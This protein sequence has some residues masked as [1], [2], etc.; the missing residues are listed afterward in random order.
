[1]N[2]RR[3]SL[4]Q[5]RDFVRAVNDELGYL[6]GKEEIE[7]TRDWSSASKLNSSSLKQYKNVNSLIVI[8]VF[9][10]PS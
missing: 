4:E 9:K 10:N 7:V 2:G 8:I 6:T 5:L 1:M 3:K